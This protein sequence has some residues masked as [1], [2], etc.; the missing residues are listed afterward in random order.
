M[1][2]QT[3]DILAISLTES[4]D[5][6]PATSTSCASPAKVR[7][8]DQSEAEFQ[9]IR[10]NYVPKIE[11]GNIHRS[12]PLP[13]PSGANKH[14]IQEIIH[15]VE[16]LYFFRRFGDAIN[17]MQKVFESE[18]EAKLLDEATKV[19]LTAYKNRCQQVLGK[20]E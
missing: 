17:F 6:N 5:D 11:N 18:T 7:R 9:A 2:D 16:E 8:T 13:L 1:D 20:K 4:D 19:L 15:A 10:E 3:N 12:V 14:Q